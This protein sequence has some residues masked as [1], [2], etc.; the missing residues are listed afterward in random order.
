MKLSKAWELYKRDKKV[1]GYS[2]YTLESYG[3]YHKKLVEFTKDKKVDEVTYNEM[4]DYMHHLFETGLSVSSVI[5]HIRQL[6]SFYNWASDEGLVNKNEASR[7]RQ[8]KTPESRPNPLSLYEIESLRD[9]CKTPQE[10][11]IFEFL[12]A[13]GCRVG[14]MVK[15]DKGDID[16]DNRSLE[17]IGKGNKKRRVYFD[18]RCEIWLKKYIESR[19]DNVDAL[20]VTARKYKA[21]GNQPRRVSRDMVRWTLTRLAQ[22]SGV[23]NVHPHRLRHSFAMNMLENGAPMEA[24]QDFLGHEDPKYTEVY[25]QLTSEMK[26]SI[27]DKYR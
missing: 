25:A 27:Y 5:I 23:E 22:R 21:E 6:K 2:H 12:Y 16:W 7:I 11:A 24:I 3:I 14:E 17:V 10:R 8:P 20:F 9:A 13:T 26:K 1:L 15:V 18:L 4:K 19:D